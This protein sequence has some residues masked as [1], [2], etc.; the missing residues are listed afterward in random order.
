MV[1]GE[2]GPLEG[3]IAAGGLVEH[4]DMRLD[5]FILDQPGKVRGG[6]VSGIGHQLLGPQ[7]EALL[8]A[9]DHPALGGHLGLAH[10][11]CRLDIDDHRMVEVDQI[12]G[13]VGV[14]GRLARRRG[15]ARS[16]IG[17]VDPLRA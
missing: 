15:P 16:G 6:A 3:V 14:E 7:A 17:E 4:G 11:G 5:A 10:R 12:V 2:G 1:E 9:L 13:G 8:R